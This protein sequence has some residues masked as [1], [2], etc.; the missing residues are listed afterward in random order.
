MMA[1]KKLFTDKENE[2]IVDCIQKAELETSGEIRVHVENRCF[3]DPVKKAIKI[4]KKTGMDRT[5]ARNGVLIYLASASKKFAIIGDKGINEKV[6]DG[7]WDETAK[8]MQIFF[9]EGNFTEG[10][11]AGIEDAGNK[12]REFFPYQGQKDKN[13]LSDEISR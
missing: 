5:E 11:K 9:I 1:T 2:L 8:K 13:E 4:F 7:F 12:L 6:P 10:L 3:G